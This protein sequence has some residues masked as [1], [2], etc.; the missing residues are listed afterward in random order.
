MFDGLAVVAGCTRYIASLGDATD[1]RLSIYPNHPSNHPTTQ[2]QIGKETTAEE[3][4]GGMR[5]AA[6]FLELS[7]RPL[8]STPITRVVENAETAAFKSWFG[9]WDPPLVPQFGHRTS[10][11]VAAP[12]EGEAA[13]KVDAAALAALAERV[14]AEEASPVGLGDEGKGEVK[15]WRIEQLQRVEVPAERHGHFYGGDSYVVMYTTTQAQQ[16]T[17]TASHQQAIYIWQGGA[18]STDEKGAAALYAV[19]LDQ[20]HGGRPV[21]VRVVQGKE[22]AHFRRIFQGRLVVHAGGVRSGFRRLSGSGGVGAGAG[23]A[24][25]GLDAGKAIGCVPSF[26]RGLHAIFYSKPG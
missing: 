26:T 1:A 11:G 9:Q 8:A 7:G 17:A 12:A 25:P 19:E 15:V 10:V 3:K 24:E 20:G 18:S 23:A 2:P 4:K 5:L 14:A 16:T 13:V 22:P 21:Q 6:S